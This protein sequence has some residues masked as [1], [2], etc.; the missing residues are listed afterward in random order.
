M[1]ELASMLEAANP[2]PESGAGSD[3]FVPR[4]DEVWAATQ[5]PVKRR[6]RI[7][8]SSR[9]RA[10]RSRRPLALASVSTL[11]AGI[12]VA[13]LV[14]ETSGSGP[15]SALAAWSATPTRPAPGQIATAEARCHQPQSAAL[16]D[17]RGPFELLLF[18]TR[19]RQLVVCH[20]WPAGL[21]GYSD[22]GPEGTP[23]A[24]NAI[25]T[26]TCSSGG[27]G[28]RSHRAQAYLQMYGLTGKSVKQVTLRLS[29][30]ATVRA[31]TSN[32]L[33]AAWW[34][35]SHRATSIQFKTATATLTVRH[36]T[37]SSEFST[38]C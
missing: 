25:T 27:F 11:A 31:T 18:K 32:G 24:P 36:N 20:A 1:N 28:T 33:W 3:V 34:P 10:E 5:T 8:G 26:I 38:N 7:S 13:V 37:N 2:V 12:L 6:T 23:A 22:P 14:L 4:F 35:G 29:G 15:A 30:G 17:T 19:T 21:A 9:T 16:V